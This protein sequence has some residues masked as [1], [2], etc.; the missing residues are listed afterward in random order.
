MGYHRLW[1]HRSYQAGTVLRIVLAILGTM[2]FQGSIKWW[3]L[4]HR[5]HH[6]YTDDLIHDPYSAKRGF[7]FSH[8]GW[9]F[10][11]KSYPRMKFIDATDLLADPSESLQ[12]SIYKYMLMVNE[13]SCPIS[14]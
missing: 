10:A 3:V 4:R 12:L 7:W 2:A 6:R 9:I 1:S 11:K 14:A 8:M 5:L 13:Y